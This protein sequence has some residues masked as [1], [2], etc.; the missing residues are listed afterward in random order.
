MKKKIFLILLWAL[1]VLLAPG[2]GAAEM[3]A[4]PESELAR[5][6]GAGG[7]DIAL[8][9][10][11]VYMFTGSFSYTDTD[12]G[13]AVAL[14]N[15]VLSNGALRPALFATGNVDM[16]GDGLRTPLTIDVGA[17][18]DPAS[19][20]YGKAMVVLK[21]LDWLQEVHL[22]A[23]VLRFCGQE[24]GSLDLGVIHR[25][26]Y[27]WLLGAHDV[28]IDFEFGQRLSIDTLRL[29]YNTLNENFALSGIHFGAQDP[30]AP[31]DP[32]TWQM[33]GLFRIGAMAEGNPATFDVGAGADNL[34]AVVL[35][36]PMQGAIR[37]ENLQWGGQSFG[38]MAID[39]LQIH[40]LNLRFIP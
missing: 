18:D 35:N 4:M 39:G 12:T 9:A 8:D 11:S 32:A 6:S 19:P 17:V 21:A 1:S 38:P 27:Y 34:A 24:L 5:V 3:Q 16:D 15:M 30:G 2:H 33:T 20:V 31:E 10:V 23:D 25:P 37:V 28:G 29:T 13:N 40:R 36:L 26:S 22:H 14:E 7:I